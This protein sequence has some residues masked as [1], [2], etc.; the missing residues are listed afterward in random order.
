MKNFVSISRRS[1]RELSF[2]VLFGVYLIASMTWAFKADSTLLAFEFL[3]RLLLPI[4]LFIAYRKFV[5]PGKAQ[6]VL[7]GYAAV[8]VY[9]FGVAVVSEAPTDV[10]VNTAKFL[11][12]ILFFF[13]L[14]FVLHPANF[15]VRF[16]YAIPILGLIG[17]IQ[18]LTLAALIYSGHAP[19]LNNV[20]LI[21]YKNFEMPSFGVF[22]YAWG[23]I[24]LGTPYQVYRAQSFFGEPTRMA[25][26]MGV[27]TLIS[28]GL[29]RVLRSRWFLVAAVLGLL[30][31]F[32]C[33]SMT[34]DVVAFLTVVFYFV[35]TRWR[36]MGYAGPTTVSVLAV[37]AV[38]LVVSYLRLATSF[39][40][41]D[42]ATTNMA[43]G[44]ADTEVSLRV[45]FVQDSLRLVRD[46]PFGIG[47]IGIE[48]S[49]ILTQYPGAG[50]VIAPFE[51]TTKGGLIGLLL[52]LVLLGYVMKTIVVRQVREGGLQ[53]YVALA[54]VLV[55][56]HHCVAG[57][58]M[59]AMFLFL[60]AAV[61]MLDRYNF[62][63]AVVD[64]PIRRDRHIAIASDS[65]LEGAGA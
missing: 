6:L 38:L 27:V 7:V 54:F 33:F 12:P 28:W 44:H 36:K 31:G 23:S 20:V 52:Q 24:A 61:L 17:A 9:M 60:L 8:I 51:W 42:L 41:Q 2:S 21:G 39:Y 16:L 5:P 37:I 64:I 1:A 29:Y 19:P 25:S 10:I 14:V 15:S 22:G 59:D 35:V 32:M 11:H 47:V 46:H 63:G 13:A 26:F 57:E 55:L 40:D 48:D 3:C 45:E 49:R 4:V 58:W 65:R 34:V 43:L 62:V 50:S 56:L 30:T 18:T 53:R